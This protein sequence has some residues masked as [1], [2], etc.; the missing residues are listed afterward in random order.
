MTTYDP[1]VIQR[2]A[3]RLYAR[4]ALSAVVS[5]A[6][7][8]LIGLVAAPFILQSLPSALA[9]RC[10]EW[11]PPAVLG[12]IGLGQG[13]ERGTQ[14]RLQAQIALCQMRIERNTR[15]HAPAEKT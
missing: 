7:G 1:E 3:D 2:S 15:A 9:L 6:L 5:T 12:L 4:A 14:L 8:M 10:P 13:L 11:L